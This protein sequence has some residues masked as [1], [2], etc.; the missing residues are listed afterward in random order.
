M[1]EDH[2]EDS[3]GAWDDPTAA[4]KKHNR[5]YSEIKLGIPEVGS[6]EDWRVGELVEEFL[7]VQTDRHYE[8]RRA[9]MGGAGFTCTRS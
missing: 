8:P 4:L 6:F 2:W 7:A 3:F 5:L 1:P 9:G